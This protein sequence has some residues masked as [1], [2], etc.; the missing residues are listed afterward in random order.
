MAVQ[1]LESELHQLR[2]EPG[3]YVAARKQYDR[4]PSW[5]AHR[6]QGGRAQAR[7]ELG[8][9]AGLGNAEVKAEHVAQIISRLTGIPVNE[10]TVEERESCCTWNQRLHRRTGWDKTR[11]S[12]PW[13]MPCGCP[14]PACASSKPVATCFWARPGGQDRARQGI[15]RIDLRR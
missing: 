2:R 3:L 7:R 10:L 13:P 14:A 5:Q 12:V 8:A 9:G 4:P 15:G 11:R 1:E 6:S